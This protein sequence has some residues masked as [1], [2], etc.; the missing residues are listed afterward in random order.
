MKRKIIVTLF[1][2][3]CVISTH[4][5]ENNPKDKTYLFKTE[6]IVETSTSSSQKFELGIRFWDNVGVD[7]LINLGKN[8][9]HFTGMFGD[10]FRL[11][12]YY[13]WMFPLEN[14]NGL[15]I[16]VGAGG[17][18]RFGDNA[19]IG[20]G[21]NLGIQYAFQFPMTL[22]F[23]WRPTWYITNKGSYSGGDYAFMARFRF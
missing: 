18:V 14:T 17:K 12:V 4:A 5:F 11:S 22:G 8:R 21:G 13:E 19:Q 2:F 3:F 7:F 1:L 15:A 16:Y 23:D 6:E 20:L 10:R 9:V